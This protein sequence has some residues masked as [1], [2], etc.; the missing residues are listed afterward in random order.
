MSGWKRQ[1][2]IRALY[3]EFDRKHGVDEFIR[4]AGAPLGIQAYAH[5]DR[6]GSW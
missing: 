2:K 3:A 4:R 6:A 1:L 5:S